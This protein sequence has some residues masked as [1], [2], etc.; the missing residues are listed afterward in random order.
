MRKGMSMT[1]S[2][3]HFL[4]AGASNC[5][6]HDPSFLPYDAFARYFLTATEKALKT[7]L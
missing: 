4:S 3:L 2:G 7:V 6:P 5:E 1:I